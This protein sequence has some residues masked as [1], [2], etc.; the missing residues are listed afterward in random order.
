VLHYDFD[1]VRGLAPGA[2]VVQPFA[3]FRD[4]DTRA[5]VMTL[6]EPAR[7]WLSAAGFLPDAQPRDLPF[8]T[9]AAD[10]DFDRLHIMQRLHVTMKD[11]NLAKVGTDRWSTFVVADFINDMAKAVPVALG[12]PQ[13]NTAAQPQIPGPFAGLRGKAAKEA[14]AKAAPRGWRPK[15]TRIPF[16]VLAM[17][18]RQGLLKLTLGTALLYCAVLLYIYR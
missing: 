6:P 17:A 18:R 15:P 11:F 9:Y 16:G 5:A 14:L 7:H 4:A 1:I 3:V 13:V 12:V 10:D 2:K 8:G